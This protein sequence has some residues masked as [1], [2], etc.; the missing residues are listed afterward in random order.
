MLEMVDVQ[1]LLFESRTTSLAS[2][3]LDRKVWAL[4]PHRKIKHIYMRWV[5]TG[6]HRPVV[7]KQI[8]IF[9]REHFLLKFMQK[10]GGKHAQIWTFNMSHNS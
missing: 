7:R 4:E 9:R 2:D 3:Q 10:S 6:M 8:Q 5:T 1:C